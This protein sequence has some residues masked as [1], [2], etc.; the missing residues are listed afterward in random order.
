MSLTKRTY[1][2]LLAN[3]TMTGSVT[4]ASTKL[5]IVYQANNV[6]WG[7]SGSTINVYV[8]GTKVTCSWTVNK[9]ETW[10]GTSYKTKMTSQQLTINKPFF[11][12]KLTDSADGDEIFNKEFSFYE[13]EKTPTA[14]TTSGGVM[15]GSTMSRVVFTTSGT[16][17]TYSAT[18]TLGSYTGTATSSTTTLEYAIPI[19]WCNAVPNAVTAQANV[20]CQ[21]KYGGVVYSS[22]TVKLTVSVPSSVVPTVT[23]ITLADRTDTLVPSTWNMFI[24]HKSGVRVSAITAAGAYSS[25][26]S[27]IKLQVGTQSI[28]QNYSASSLP[29]IDTITQSGSLTCTVTVTDSRG[30]TASKTA[31]VTFVPYAAPKFTN[32]VSE[33]CLA[34][35]DLDNDGT[36]FKSTTA[37]SFSTCNGNNTITLTVKYKKT[38][39]VLYGTESTI[40]PGVNT[41]GNDDLDTEFSYDVMYSVSDQFCTVTYTD[42]ISTAIYLM[43]FL[44]GGKGVAF[45]QKATTENYLDC[46]FKALFRDDVYFVTGNGVQVN[47]R[48]IITIGAQTLTSFSDGL[49]LCAQNG[50]LIAQVPSIGTGTPTSLTNGQILY[51][52]NGNIGSKTLSLSDLSNGVIKAGDSVAT[53]GIIFAVGAV[54]SNSAD[55]YIDVPLGK[56]IT[57]SSATVTTGVITI[58]TVDGYAWNK[59]QAS[60]GTYSGL[61]ITQY[62]PVCS[63]HKAS[64]TVRVKITNSTKWVTASGTAIANNT[65]AVITCNFTIKFA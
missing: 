24:Q 33:R 17:A 6:L 61:D 56:V 49:Y 16:D 20:T 58:R 64:G 7:V 40:T 52:N 43:H 31:T 30:R 25:T 62:S 39:A 22:F 29:Q 28:S 54:T 65:P 9:T 3:F 51:A 53:S 4:G 45:G 36:Y 44:H 63:L 27:K 50:K 5:T 34:N 57:A 8:D 35:G 15:D 26:I 2:E 23:S 21:V 55:L 13:I 32:C 10:M 60:G 46:A 1:N 47:I 19:T 37:V 42:Y 48:D 59:S 14:A 11:T 38:D 12:L 18:F 41:C